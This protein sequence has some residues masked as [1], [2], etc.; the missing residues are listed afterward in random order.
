MTRKGGQGNMIINL[1]PHAIHLPTGVLEPSGLVARCEEKS[2][3]AGSLDGVPIITRTYGAV[4][5][6]PHERE[7]TWY[8]VS[9]MCRVAC[10][11]RLDLVSPG[12][13]TRDDQGR[14]TGCTNLVVNSVAGM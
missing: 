4:S 13:L 12:D 6:L 3:A 10:P 5:N 11:H 1:T 2:T 8:V 9:H 7:G 14:I